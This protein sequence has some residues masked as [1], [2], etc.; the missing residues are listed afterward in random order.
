MTDEKKESSKGL[1]DTVKKI[2]DKMGIKQ[3]GACKKRQAKLNRLFPY[4]PKDNNKK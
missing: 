3:C 2:T 1:G 4:E